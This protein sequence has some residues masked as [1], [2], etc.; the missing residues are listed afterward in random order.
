MGYWEEGMREAKDQDG[1]DP[2]A[3]TTGF[4]YQWDTEHVKSVD[5][6][7]GD[8][9]PRLRFLKVPERS[10]GLAAYAASR[11]RPAE[12]KRDAVMSCYPTHDWDDEQSA[13]ANWIDAV[14]T[15][16]RCG[17]GDVTAMVAQGGNSLAAWIHMLKPIT[18]RRW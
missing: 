16:Q 15:E 6:D 14:A 17:T 1:R 8:A 18:E 11:K 4:P 2:E 3:T 9:T 12:Q 5:P 7:S 13:L 10:E